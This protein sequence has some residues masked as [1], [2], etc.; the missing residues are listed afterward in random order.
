VSTAEFA[1]ARILPGPREAD[2]TT[3]MIATSALIPAA[4]TFSWLRGLLRHRAVTPWAP[5]AA[6]LFDRDGTLVHDEPYNGRPELVRP[7]AGATAA[8]ARL[9]LA[10]LRVGVVSNQSGVA[11]GLI[12]TGDVE[13]VNRR[14]DELLGPF[15]TWQYCPH[16]DADG[17][18]RRKPQPGMVI[19]AARD[20]GVPV[21]HCVVIGDTAA[22]VAAA[23]AAGATGILVPNR[24]TRAA[25][26]R[27]AEWTAPDLGAA[28]EA[29]LI[30]AGRARAAMPDAPSARPAAASGGRR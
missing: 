24:A 28:V 16:D 4:A 8:I 23:A 19:D 18:A 17:C 1:T 2:E 12:G 27:A 9:R 7:V 30:R 13:A 5:V 25:E 3:R 21:A 10:G 29:V 15:D 20:L 22:D 26:V 14:V 11:R 6:V